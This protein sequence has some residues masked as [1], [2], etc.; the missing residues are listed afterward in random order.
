MSN[1]SVLSLS[2]YPSRTNRFFLKRLVK[3]CA[4][5]S[6]TSPALFGLFLQGCNLLGAPHDQVITSAI[7]GFSG[8]ELISM[9][10]FRPSVPLLALLHR[11]ITSVNQEYILLRQYV[12]IE[13][14]FQL[15]IRAKLIVIVCLFHSDKRAR[16]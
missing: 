12:V 5:H 15:R 8:G 11:R 1:A 6:A 4:V 10:Q 14:S 16:S 13:G 2:S 7:R 9:I 3:Y